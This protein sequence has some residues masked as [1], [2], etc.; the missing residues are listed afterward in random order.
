[1]E[2][3]CMQ[4]MQ[5]LKLQGNASLCGA[6][7]AV[8]VIVA[9]L[10]LTQGKSK[11]TNVPASADVYLMIDVLREL[12]AY[13]SFDV[14]NHVLEIDTTSVDKWSV[15]KDNMSRMRASIL[16][17]GPLLARFGRADIAIPGGCS[18]GL[19][20]I[21]YHLKNFSKM[22]VT[23]TLH[24]EYVHA[25]VTH[26]KS[27][28][29][30]FEYPSVGATENIM[31]AAVLTQG[32]THIVNASLEPEV[33]DLICVLRKMGSH[34][35]IVAPATIIINGVSELHPIEHAVINDRLEA[36][37]LLCAAAITGGFIRLPDAS[38][39]D[40]DVV[41]L[42]LDE[43]GHT[44]SVDSTN[45]GISLQATENPRAVSFKT[46]PFPSFPTDLQAVMMSLL[47]FSEGV[48]IVEETVYENRLLHIP[49]LIKMGA[50]ITVQGSKAIITGVDRLYGTA[51][52]ATDIRASS[53]LVLAGLRADGD[54]YMDGLHHWR[55]GYDALEKKLIAIGARIII[56]HNGIP[57]SVLHRSDYRSCEK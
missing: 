10:L 56:H 31:L 1:M 50:R 18:I 48:S 37:T 27:A 54:T 34:I 53:A 46:G 44:I 6:K 55:R 21:D 19:R 33:L 39:S 16:V 8:L 47:C 28:R 35:E 57:R 26:L 42:K 12:G 13:V 32:T 24:G 20:P 52:H 29:I 3:S 49:E 14:E 43:M 23:V 7:N 4:I 41:L 17:M 5:S 36:G 38:A 9:S 40:L 45:R 30:I 11:L 25:Q 51:V 2:D 22:G 15:S